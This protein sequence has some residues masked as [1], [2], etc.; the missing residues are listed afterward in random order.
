EGAA[1][2][3]QR[4]PVELPRAPDRQRL[5]LLRRRVPALRGT[6]VVAR[7]EADGRTGGPQDQHRPRGGSRRLRTRAPTTDFPEAGGGRRV[8]PI[9][10]PPPAVFDAAPVWRSGGARRCS[11]AAPTAPL[12][13]TG[14]DC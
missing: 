13:Q 10:P 6:A 4:T 3:R 5:R 14:A 1:G 7:Q 12:R 9:P 11:R 2:R 8:R